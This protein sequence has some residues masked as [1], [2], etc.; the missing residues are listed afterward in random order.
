VLE[1]AWSLKEPQVGVM[2]KKTYK[3]LQV[4]TRGDIHEE[5]VDP[6]SRF[7]PGFLG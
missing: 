1:A 5:F 6:G 4:A 7:N 3:K 2:N